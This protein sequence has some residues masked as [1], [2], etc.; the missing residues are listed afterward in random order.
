MP[1][2]SSSGCSALVNSTATGMSWPVSAPYRAKVAG[3]WLR[4]TPGCSV[5][6]S[7]SSQDIRAISSTMC[8]RNAVASSAL[9]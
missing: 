9:A 2:R 3:W 5:I 1:Y 4:R 6:T 7:P 8:R